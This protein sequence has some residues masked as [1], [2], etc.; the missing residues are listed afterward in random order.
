[1]TELLT[2][3]DKLPQIEAQL[4]TAEM[5]R[6]VV[7]VRIRFDPPPLSAVANDFE[8]AA[9]AALKNEAD[10][11]RAALIMWDRKVAVLSEI[12]DEL[13]AV[14]AATAKGE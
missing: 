4:R 7:S 8:K 13:K 9:H 3:R 2:A 10:S 1:M 12:H 14:V 11:N 5:E 6:Y